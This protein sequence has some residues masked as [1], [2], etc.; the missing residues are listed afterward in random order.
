MMYYDNS[1]IRQ[2]R[3]FFI[4]YLTNDIVS[5]ISPPAPRLV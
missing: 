2:L 4:L 5:V 3:Y 1:T